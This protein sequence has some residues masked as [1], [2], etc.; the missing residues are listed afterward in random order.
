MIKK[1]IKLIFFTIIFIYQTSVFSK[2]TEEIDFNPKY[3]SGYLSALISK[4]NQN[5][6]DS[7][8]YFNSSKALIN[9]HEVFL[10][11][12]AI[13]LVN[14]GEVNKSINVIKQNRYK[15]NSD[16]FE[17]KLL[18]LIENFKKKNF[19][20]NIK[21]LSELEKYRDYDNY[22]FII[23]EVLRSYNELFLTRELS[24]NQEN[25]G[26]LSLINEAF[27][28][29]YLN[30]TEA[31]SKFLNLFNSEEGDYTRYLFFY[32]NNLIEKKKF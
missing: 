18:L 28:S 20:Q 14:N 25:F 7:V 22:H 3:L 10:N 19:Y 1:K 11:K 23:Y 15:S 24:T 6:R 29:C 2:T 8:K 21:L 12:Y 32:L 31:N 17:A 5:S 13:T 9:N 27:Q 26:K 4:N 30:Q 16:F